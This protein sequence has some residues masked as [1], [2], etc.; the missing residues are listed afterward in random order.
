MLFSSGI[1][2]EHRRRSRR[3]PAPRTSSSRTSSTTRASWTVSPV[4]GPRRGLPPR[5][6]RPPRGAVRRVRRA[7]PDRRHRHRLLDGRRPRSARRPRRRCASGTTRCSSWTRLTRPGCSAPTGRAPSRS[8]ASSARPGRR[9]HA[10]EGARLGRRV[11]RDDDAISRRSSATARA[12]TSSTPRRRRRRS[13]RREA[14]LRIV[15]AEPERRERVRSLARPSPTSCGA[16]GYD[17]REPA[18]AVVPVHVGDAR[19][20]VA[21]SER[22]LERGVFCP[23][24]RPPSVPDGTSRLRVTVMATHT[25]EQID[26]A[27][28]RVRGVDETSIERAADAADASHAIVFVTGTDTGVGKTIVTAAI[29]QARS[30]RAGCASPSSSRSKRA[31]STGTTTRATPRD[32]QRLRRVH[33]RRARRSARTVGRGRARRTSRSTSGRIVETFARIAGG[34]RRRGRRGCRRA[35]RPDRRRRRRWPSSRASSALPIVIVARPALGTLNHTALTVE[36]GAG[37]RSGR[38]RRRDLAVPR[39]PKLAE[40]TN[41]VEIEKL[42]DVALIGVVPRLATVDA[43]SFQ[44]AAR[45]LG[46]RFGGCFDRDAFL[47]SLR[48]PQRV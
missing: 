3:S 14:A 16:L 34:L 5:R 46:P 42:C 19:E 6:R 8:S 15:G 23:A 30:R 39:Q 36:V 48:D 24:I 32:S 33:R 44:D 11:R 47:A 10:L 20:A 12:R 22:L 28:R 35:A 25:D 43:M 37:S 9:R 26:R 13:R 18:A 1:P 29:A 45:W 31:R 27:L 41:P 17:A 2:R 38:R 4:E 21:L 7:P 40:R